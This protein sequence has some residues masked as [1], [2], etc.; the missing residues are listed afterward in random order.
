MQEGKIT[1]PN[2]V[3]YTLSKTAN[4]AATPPSFEED[5]FVRIKYPVWSFTITLSLFLTMKC[6]FFQYTV[7]TQ[8]PMCI[9]GK[10]PVNLKI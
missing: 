3:R 5:T 8:L 2:H 4:P 9:L 6:T 10:C 7:T 1:L